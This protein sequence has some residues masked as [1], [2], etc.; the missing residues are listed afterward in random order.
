MRRL[1]YVCLAGI[2]LFGISGCFDGGPP[3]LGEL[4]DARAAHVTR[5]KRE[6][7][8]NAPLPATVAV[9]P[10]FELTA[11]DGP[12]GRM[13]ALMSR[14]PSAD[15]K[16]PVI[17]WLVGGFGN[18]VYEVWELEEPGNDQSASAF[19]SQGIITLF[20]SLRGGH[21]NTGFNESFYGE[22]DD[23]IAAAKHVARL[24]YVD[25]TRIYLGGHSTGGT[26]AL[27]V[28]E[29]SDQFRAIFALGPVGDPAGYG[30]ELLHYDIADHEERRLRAPAGPSRMIL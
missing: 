1:P 30:A 20:P 18:G 12:S 6:V 5:L 2:V 4:R 7:S 16:Y 22:V 9:D 15:R 17:I 25:P 23:V 21:E 19:W 24:P 14:A 3:E 28:A 27:L 11:Y 8:S 13:P 29:C 10:R 26:L